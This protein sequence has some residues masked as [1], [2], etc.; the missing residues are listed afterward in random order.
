MAAES[1]TAAAPPPR[2][3][4]ERD[5]YVPN[6]KTDFVLTFVF[7]GQVAAL[8]FSLLFGLVA[9]PHSPL[10]PFQSGLALVAACLTV[11]PVILVVKF[12]S[13]VVG[14]LMSRTLLAHLGDPLK[15]P[16]TM[17]KFQDQM[18]QL[19]IHASM[20]AFEY[21][22]L[23]HEDGGVKWWSDYAT[24]W[25]PHASVQE[26]KP[27]VHLFY[28]IQLAIWIDTCFSHKFIEERHKDYVMMY[29]HHIVTII[30]VA[31]SYS[32]NYLRIGT[33][34]L[35]VHDVSD[36]PLDLIKILNYLKCEGPKGLFALELAFAGNLV[37]WAYI[38][39][40]H[41]PRNVIWAVIYGA[42]EV[43]HHDLAL[44][45]FNPALPADIGVVPNEALHLVN[46]RL[47]RPSYTIG[48]GD[49]NLLEDIRINPTNFYIRLYWTTSV[50]L[51]TLFVMHIFWYFLLVK[52]LYKMLFKTMHEAGQETYEGDSDDDDKDD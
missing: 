37:S 1:S 35:F 13:R 16:K 8:L 40:W 39:L 36:V 31:G 18:W 41:Y 48:A 7:L 45:K 17:H 3:K 33:V 22:I 11:Y 14:G 25:Q 9:P 26:N 23:F 46:G 47:G 43:M 21:Y 5:V 2:T 32:Y 28:L 30:L 27:S 4:R 10:T 42:R 6:P 12:F 29:V 51:T 38:R 34:V 50:L 24:I 49:F 15:K 20:S 19:F 44:G 52:I